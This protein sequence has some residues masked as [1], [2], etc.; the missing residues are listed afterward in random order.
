MNIEIELQ[1]SF[2]RWPA[3]ITQ[4]VN[5]YYLAI[6]HIRNHCF[7]DAWVV[8]SL[9]FYG[10]WLLIILYSAHHTKSS[11]SSWYRLMRRLLVML[12]FLKV[13]LALQREWLNISNLSGN[14]DVSCC[15][16][17]EA[18]KKAFRWYQA[19]QK[20][21]SRGWGGTSRTSE[22]KMSLKAN[23]VSYVTFIQQIP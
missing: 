18:P 5:F 2:Q 3:K 9:F 12:S 15:V 7:N 11:I 17:T 13:I 10:L 21:S 20:L 6:Y 1:E 16:N 8:N 23:F 22:S 19:L 14:R 4:I